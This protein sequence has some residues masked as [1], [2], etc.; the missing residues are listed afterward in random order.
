[1]VYNT[2]FKSLV[3][4]KEKFHIT[5]D[6]VK[7]AFRDWNK[8]KL[9]LARQATIFGG[10]RLLGVTDNNVPIFASY[11][12]DKKTL[13]LTLKLT[14]SIDTIRN[15][16]YCPRRI[17]LGTNENLNNLEFAMRPASKL[18]HGEITDKSIDYLEK[19]ITMVESSSIG[20]VNGKCSTQLFMHVSNFIHAGS[21]ETGKFRWHDVM[22]TWNMPSGQY[23]TIY[24]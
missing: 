18:D 20:K 8:E 24:G 9:K 23:L 7:K 21:P 2:E 10:R 1:M 19:L 12:I 5:D 11:E 3:T 17:T 15:S 22:K 4:A 13:T 6:K 14:H 16:K